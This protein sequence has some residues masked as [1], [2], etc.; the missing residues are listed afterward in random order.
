M[1]TGNVWVLT[2]PDVNARRNGLLLANTSVTVVAAIGDWV[3]V[4]WLVEEL[5]TTARGWVLQQWIDL[6]EPINESIITPVPTP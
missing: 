2:E 4:E 1:I 6:A 5:G 3:E